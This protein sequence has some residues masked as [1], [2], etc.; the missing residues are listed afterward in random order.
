MLYPSKVTRFWNHD[1]EAGLILEKHFL[2]KPLQVQSLLVSKSRLIQES[3][4]CA[5][6][7]F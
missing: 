2:P 6:Y 5:F 4:G 7:I 3:F 1:P